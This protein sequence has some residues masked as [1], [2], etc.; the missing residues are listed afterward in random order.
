MQI[1]GRQVST[2]RSCA[3]RTHKMRI[4]FAA[5]CVLLLANCTGHDG[6]ADGERAGQTTQA[7]GHGTYDTA[8][9]FKTSPR[10]HAERSGRSTTQKSAA[11]PTG[12]R[13]TACS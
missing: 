11:A 6:G 8:D 1:V 7:V 2:W 5:A 10:S 3:R 9:R 13:T 12:W 4:P